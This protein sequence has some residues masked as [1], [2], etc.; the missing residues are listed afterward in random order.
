MTFF[1][2]YFLVAFIVLHAFMLTWGFR[3]SHERFGFPQMM[4][5]SSYRPF[6]HRILVPVII[7]STSALIPQKF[8]DAHEKWF[9]EQS[10]IIRYE[11]KKDGWNARISLKYHLTYLFLFLILISLQFS[12]RY[13]IKLIYKPGLM[14]FS[15]FPAIA[16]L[17]LPLTFSEGGYF[18][19]FPELLLLGLSLILLI[20]KKWLLYYAVFILAVLNK[21]SNVLLILFFMAFYAKG[22]LQ[23]EYRRHLITQVLIASIITISIRGFFRS[24]PGYGSVFPNGLAENIS[25]LLSFK[26]YFLFFDP[27]HLGLPVFPKGLNIVSILSCSFL[28]FYKWKEKPKNVK[29]LFIFTLAVLA[30]IYIYSGYL[31]EI[32]A[33]SLI[34]PAVFLLSFHSIYVLF[35][36]KLTSSKLEEN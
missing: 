10:P 4:T 13:L 3:G 14:L 18:Y 27:Y 7:N 24:W 32:R 33:L 11:Q 30:P 2:I 1:L 26:T 34:F 16:L 20:K 6:V 31:P 19:D 5:Y 23:N 21:E 25:I 15:L 12:M 29:R 28:I 9:T 22:L 35:F 8:T 17:F 36:K